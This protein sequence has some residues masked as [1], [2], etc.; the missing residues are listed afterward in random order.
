MVRQLNGHFFARYPWITITV[1]R[2]MI[3][4][5]TVA[6]FQAL[7]VRVPRQLVDVGIFVTIVCRIRTKT[8][9]IVLIKPLQIHFV[10]LFDER[11]GWRRFVKF[12]ID[13]LIDQLSIFGVWNYL[14][15]MF[16]FAFHDM[17]FVAFAL[18]I[19]FATRT[20]GWRAGWGRWFDIATRCE[21]NGLKS[22][23]FRQIAAVS[24][25]F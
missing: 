16:A 11:D 25:V 21:I 4:V 7:L 13:V 9:I 24:F 19:A 3:S 1:I 17:S 12:Q 18:V 6:I 5:I 2:V 10:L 8:F 20:L 23:V 22:I 15:V 14:C